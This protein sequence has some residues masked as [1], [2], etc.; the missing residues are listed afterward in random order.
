MKM[1]KTV[2]LVMFLAA[3][4]QF[5]PFSRVFAVSGEES[6][7]F[8]EVPM[9]VSA[10]KVA[11]KL[12][13]APAFVT[14]YSSEDIR[15][16]GY[17]TIADLAQITP[18]YNVSPR[19]GQLTLT[20]RGDQFS[21]ENAD[22]L[23]LIDGIPINFP[24]SYKGSDQ[25][26]LPL[27]FADKVEF[28]RGPSSALYG[29]SAFSGVVSITSKK[30]EE[31][32]T[33]TESRFS[34]GFQNSQQFMTDII[35]KNDNGETQ[36]SASYFQKDS[37][38]RPIPTMNPP[39]NLLYDGQKDTFINSSYKITK[40]ALKGFGLGLI[41]I[42][43]NDDLSESWMGTFTEPDNYNE[44]RTVAPYLKYD[45]A[46]SDS[47]SIDGYIKSNMGE[48]TGHFAEVPRSSNQQ[49]DY[50]YRKDCAGYDTMAEI[51]YKINAKYDLIA[52]LEYDERY[53]VDPGNP[54]NGSYWYTYNASGKGTLF[55]EVNDTNI[56]IKTM[57]AFAQL[58]RQ[59]FDVL[60]GLNLILG[61][62]YDDGIFGSS[63]YSQF[64]PRTGLV[65]KL[66]DNWNVKVMYDTALRVPTLKDYS[67]NVEAGYQF[68]QYGLPS[69]LPSSI[70]P[71][72]IQSYQG[73]I[74]Y[75]N[76]HFLGTITMFSDEIDNAII[77]HAA[78]NNISYDVNASGK[79]KGHGVEVTGDY[80]LSRAFKLFANYSFAY[81]A[82]ENGQQF[83][84]IPV[85]M[86]NAGVVCKIPSSCDLKCT[87]V[88]R[89]IDK[90]TTTNG[91]NQP[92]GNTVVDFKVSAKIAAATTL[93]FA[94][95]N[96][97][98]EDYLVPENGVPLY[99]MPDRQYM[100]SVNVKL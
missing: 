44:F 73:G 12:T 23:I 82:D 80:A 96:L 88:C 34:G 71:E 36:L 72:T 18:G 40:G 7:L 19:W 31:N 62:R 5:Q 53:W 81:F 49:S 9:V 41:Y 1:L 52:G 56:H 46:F 75:E 94:I 77:Q 78:A 100:L 74:T 35:S 98:N 83:A 57:S 51:K 33:Q 86:V 87:A 50:I 4:V 8:M 70:D 92:N 65:Q 64:S 68:A 28:L 24:L 54:D 85:N 48:E 90:Y 55:S 17:Y 16:L 43:E 42:D 95:Q 15:D 60:A 84:D 6:L 76:K 22:N 13:D 99:P 66:N 79:S 3:V 32:G 14:S 58:R 27:L 67:R 26:D 20:T 93:E 29:A 97:G 2:M 63:S 37:S 11:E 45:H 47:F 69:T 38:L 30:M 39:D 59:Q 91:N 89:Y 61:A 25:Q 10:S 21:F